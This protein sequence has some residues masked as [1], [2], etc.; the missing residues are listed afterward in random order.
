M[1]EGKAPTKSEIV[2]VEFEIVLVKSGMV[3]TESGS[4]SE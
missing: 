2:S 4:V 3:P 1:R